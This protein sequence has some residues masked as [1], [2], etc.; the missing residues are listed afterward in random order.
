MI[1][2]ATFRVENNTFAERLQV[3]I[4]EDKT[5]QTIKKNKPRRHRGLY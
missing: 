2:A 1:L 3:A 5:T 4:Q